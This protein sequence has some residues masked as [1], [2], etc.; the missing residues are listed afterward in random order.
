MT[1]VAL[2]SLP[3]TRSPRP[4]IPGLLTHTYQLRVDQVEELGAVR[5]SGLF[6][7]GAA[8]ENRRGQTEEDPCKEELHQW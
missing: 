6:G 5:G 2:A 7:L 4:C 1:A 8:D 3:R